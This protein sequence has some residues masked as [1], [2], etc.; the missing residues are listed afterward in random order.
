[1]RHK[2]RGGTVDASESLYTK[3]SFSHLFGIN[4]KVGRE[5]KVP[6]SYYATVVTQSPTVKQTEPTKKPKL[7]H[8]PRTTFEEGTLSD[9]SEFSSSEESQYTP[10]T[11]EEWVKRCKSA[12]S[13]AAFASTRESATAVNSEMEDME[14]VRSTMVDSGI[15]Q[16][17]VLILEPE[18]DI[19]DLTLSP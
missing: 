19:I 1:M 6:P 8:I 14:L 2:S 18:P 10:I 5:Y 13:T 11:R 4:K 15:T 3:E 7:L 12:T 17:D 9:F 16:P